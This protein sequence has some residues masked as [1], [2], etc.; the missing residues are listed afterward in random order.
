MQKKARFYDFIIL[1]LL[2]L[3]AAF[4]SLTLA[5]QNEIKPG[6]NDNVSGLHSDGWIEQGAE[7]DLRG[8][9]RWGNTFKATFDT[10]R[11]PGMEPALVKI[12][13]CQ[14]VVAE[15]NL[16][17]S[18][19]V[20]F[21]INANCNERVLKFEFLNP[22][23]VSIE[24]P[25]QLG[26]KLVFASIT[27]PIKVAIVSIC[28]LLVVATIFFIC[29][30]AVRH[31]FE[32]KL[33]YLI[34]ISALI[35]FSVLI[36]RSEKLIYLYP[37]TCLLLSALIGAYVYS[38]ILE[39]R[40]FVERA[41]AASIATVLT[42]I[43]VILG[44]AL[45]FYNIDFGLPQNF[46][47]DE[48]PKVNA[49]MRMWNSG[50]LNPEY[51][52]HPTLLLYTTY[53]M[54]FL[55]HSFGFASGEF[56]ESAFLAGRTVSALAGTASIF[57]TYIIGSRLFSKQ[58]GCVAAFL[59]AVFPI[60]VT[61]SRYLKEDSLLLALTLF[62][63][64][65]LLKATEENKPK[66]LFLSALVAGFAAS[67]KYSGALVGGLIVLAPWLR[68]K[69]LVPDKVFL[70]YTVVALLFVP[71]GF[72]ISTPY[73]LIT[74]EKFI[75]DLM[76]EKRHMSKG[77]T[78]AIDAWSQY[79]TYYYSRSIMPG[80]T[81]LVT[82]ISGVSLGLL[83]MRKRVTDLFL[84]FLLLVFYV[85]A[86][87][88]SSKPA[89]QPERYIL[90]CIPF[91]ALLCAEFYRTLVNSKLKFLAYI[92]LLALFTAPLWRS[93]ELAS[94]LKPDT[95]EILAQ[96]VD[97]NIPSGSKIYVDWEAYS[98]KLSPE[99]YQVQYLSGTSILE[100]LEPKKLRNSDFEYLI[101]SSLFFNRYFTEPN[102]EAAPRGR[103][104]EVFKEFPMIREVNSEHG[105]Y[106]FHNPRL[107]LFS[108]KNNDQTVDR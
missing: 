42:L 26:A 105:T 97:K 43:A 99:K 78:S 22:F 81:T 60:H 77:H 101:L 53:A 11:P 83:L 15:F 20:A 94:E 41:D 84:I 59:L 33:S 65:L 82:I 106:G 54:N 17:D 28:T 9:S 47:P 14:K 49:V 66:I 62:S 86:E 103:I 46:H 40:S 64:V 91:I 51:F 12:H 108:L 76:Y 45:R 10:W 87:W 37:P 56:R 95:R 50:T 57:F 31:I 38:V 48:V 29:C 30:L 88:V 3:L 2:S 27:S 100:L 79:W 67:T 19:T 73:S 90:P 4:V 23:T 55:F 8:L 24:D 44:A 107:V 39:K 104:R 7:I 35:F 71:L 74:S 96:W 80:V 68:S 85:P 70:K 16:K 34:C 25:R 58:T 18:D 89:P 1:S 98:P 93:I 72:V 32:R 5:Y 21:G 52:L 92:M 75:K 13:L 61:C 102:I 69:T 36:F 6:S 63:I